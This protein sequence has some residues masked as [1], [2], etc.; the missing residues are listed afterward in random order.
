MN[1]VAIDIL[2]QV[3]NHT[4]VKRRSGKNEWGVGAIPFQHEPWFRWGKNAWLNE[5]TEY[6]K[7]GLKDGQIAEKMGITSGEFKTRYKNALNQE[8]IYQISANQALIEAGYTNRSERARMMGV[9]ESTIRSLENSISRER[10]ERAQATADILKRQIDEKGPIDISSGAELRLGVSKGKMK[11]AVKILEDQG[12]EKYAGKQEQVTNE[13]MFTTM[14]FL[15]PPG[16]GHLNKQGKLVTTLLYDHPEQIHL[17]DITGSQLDVTSDDNGLTFRKAFQYP[18][19]MDSKRIFIRYGEEGA[20]NDGTIEIRPGVPDLNLGDSHY[21]QVRILVD[22]T[23]YM[24]GMAFYSN[25]IPEGYDVVYNSRKPTNDPNEVF[26]KIGKDPDNPFGSLIKEHGGQSTYIDPKTGE[27]KLSLINKRSD[28]GDWNEWS[29]KLAS[30]FLS[31]QR[32]ELVNQQLNLSIAEK[33]DELD[34][35]LKLNNPTLKKHFL[36]D[37]AQA[38]DKAAVELKASALPGQKYKVILPVNSL[39]ENECYCPEYENG[40]T[41]ALIRYPHGGTFE[42]PIVKVNNRNP[43]GKSKLGTSPLDAIGINYKVAQRLSGADFDGDTVLIIPNADKQHVLATNPLR[44]LEGFDP[45]EKYGY[46]N[47]YG[48]IDFDN[49]ELMSKLGIKIMQ[50]KYKQIQMGVVSNLITDM[51]IK[52]APPEELAAAVRH[53]MVVIDAPKHKLDYTR[54]AKDNNIKELIKRYQGHYDLDGNWKKSGASTIISRASGKY[55]APA[56]QGD[57]HI[58]EK[59]GELEWKPKSK[60][61]VDDQT[62][63]KVEVPDPYYINKNGKIVYYTKE[64]TQMAAVKDA[65]KLISEKK[66][67]VEIAYAEYAN[68]LKSMAN[69]ARKA[70]LDP[71]LKYVYNPEVAKENREIVNNLKNK[72]LRAE[73][74]APLE[75][76]AQR[77]AT[78]VSKEKFK[79]DESLTEKEK[80]KIRQQSIVQA[81]LKFGA[82][83]FP[84]N[85]TDDEWDVIQ[86]GGISN[87]MLEQIIQYT[88]TDKLKARAMPRAIDIPS[89]AKQARIRA[90]EDAN[91]TISE[92]AKRVDLSPTTVKKYLKVSLSREEK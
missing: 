85:V 57:P 76:A 86:K 87:H 59:T 74:N 65:N 54:S 18:A 34:T 50:E 6:K 25:D 11:Q 38:A 60:F 66:Y 71:N 39:S 83:R 16:T 33:R 31:K 91:Y 75:R 5:V 84:V 63:K 32:M 58:N 92:I 52:G 81:R 77:E 8:R 88:D 27:R 44:G 19:S 28:E 55:D 36:I 10:T 7:Q 46:V 53:S 3:V 17:I 69:E 30:Q 90:M 56:T 24:K 64:T 1:Y 61:V 43:E 70:S 29:D 37:F 47:K 12:Y 48:N 23:K 62:G 26:K 80:G 21:A 79:L 78:Y 82:E 20:K 49:K 67:P 68:T 13:G 15:C 72:I 40:T 42:I 35:I 73:S 9:N 14:T 89:E 2:D 41:L 22:D 4:G 45:E 51:T